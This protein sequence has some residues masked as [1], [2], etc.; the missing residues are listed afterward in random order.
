MKLRI[1]YI[2]SEINIDNGIVNCLEIENRDCFY[3]VISNFYLESNGQNTES[4]FFGDDLS[5]EIN[6]INKLVVIIKFFNL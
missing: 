4:L 1:S 3:K 5:K 2:D 6:K